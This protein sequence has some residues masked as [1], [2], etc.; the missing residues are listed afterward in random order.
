MDV[1]YV[2]HVLC[3]ERV[4]LQ[5]GIVVV[6]SVAAAV[7]VTGMIQRVEVIGVVEV[8]RREVARWLASSTRSR[9]SYADYAGSVRPYGLD[10][11]DM[12]HRGDERSAPASSSL[13]I[14]I[15]AKQAIVTHVDISASPSAPA[16]HLATCDLDALARPPTLVLEGMPPA[17]AGGLSVRRGLTLDDSATPLRQ[18]LVRRRTHKMR[19]ATPWTDLSTRSS[20]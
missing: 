2:D 19:M 12:P 13:G 18:A 10:N 7:S 11:V 15:A 8:M 9:R 3:Q 5:D 1:A 17:T 6:V 16:T 14:G 4:R 20:L